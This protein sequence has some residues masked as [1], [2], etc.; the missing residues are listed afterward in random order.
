[1]SEL[2]IVK[3]KINGT[4]YELVN[5]TPHPVTV[6]E[7]DGATPVVTV[8]SSGMVRVAETVR[9]CCEGEGEVALV[10]IERDPDHIEGLPG[11]NE[12]RYVIVSDLAYQAA[13][14]LGRDDLLRPGPAVRD[15]R[16]RIIGCKGLAI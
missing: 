13:K 2:N 8:P 14:P 9:V 11:Y 4:E 15:A 12:D 6:Y 1:M 10:D 5:M 7:M 16:G 3:A